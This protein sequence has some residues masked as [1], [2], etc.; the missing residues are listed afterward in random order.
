MH[1][2][3]AAFLLVTFSSVS[4]SQ[5]RHSN[6]TFKV[7]GAVLSHVRTSTSETHSRSGWVTEKTFANLAQGSAEANWGHPGSELLRLGALSCGLPGREEMAGIW[8]GS[9]GGVPGSWT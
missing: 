3:T 1:V 2:D 5:Y 7:L 6:Y 4:A 9:R 8:W